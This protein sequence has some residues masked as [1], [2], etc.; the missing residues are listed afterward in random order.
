MH[1]SAA[2]CAVT[3]WWRAFRWFGRHLCVAV[4]LRPQLTMAP[5]TAYLTNEQVPAG[6]VDVIASEEI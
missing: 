6:P 1:R 3:K 4:R 2:A 5:L